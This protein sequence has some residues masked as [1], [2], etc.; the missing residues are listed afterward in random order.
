MCF[1]CTNFRYIQS[2]AT[3]AAQSRRCFQRTQTSRGN[4]TT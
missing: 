4:S 3:R 1:H 2:S